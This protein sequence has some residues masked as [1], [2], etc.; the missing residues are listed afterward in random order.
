MTQAQTDQELR[1]LRAGHAQAA[2]ARNRPKTILYAA[3]LLLA[4]SLF[5]L[6][7]AMGDRRRQL[8]A[9]QLQ[10]DSTEAFYKLISEITTLRAQQAA[11]PSLRIEKSEDVRQ[12]IR[13][14]AP[15]AL[16][17]KL[18]T[19]K[20]TVIDKPDKNDKAA[21]AQRLVLKYEQVNHES[22]E[23]L[24]TWVGRALERVPGLEV[25]SITIKPQ[26]NVWTMSVHFSRWQRSSGSN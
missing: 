11:M 23:D 16:K 22:L 24:T 21:G 1:L 14:A 8:E 20:E 10:R 19:P 6:M 7:F 12:A 2:E 13:D 5:W 17:V 15:E 9:L 3:V 4:L 25:Y 26:Q 18:L